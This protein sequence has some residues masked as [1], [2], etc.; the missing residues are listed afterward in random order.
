MSKT[1]KK[2]R[3]SYSPKFKS[4]A[5]ELAKEI[6]TKKTAE[7]LGIQSTQTLAAWIRYSQKLDED[8]EFKEMEQ[9]RAENKRLRK[10]STEDKKVIAI[11]KDAT[12][13]FC[14]ENLK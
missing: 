8:S 7:K 10:E 4:Q 3:K 14:Q 1:Q 5:I 2:P 6:G 13:F 9:L 11:L 12:A